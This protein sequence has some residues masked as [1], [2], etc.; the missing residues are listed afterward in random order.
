MAGNNRVF[1]A[2][3]ELAI[4]PYCSASGMP[5]HGVQSVN[6]TTTFNLEQVFELGQ[7]DI[8]ENIENIPNVELTAEKVL[9]GDTMIYH[10][11]TRGATSPSLLNRSNQRADV[12][13]MIFSDAQDSASG[14]P[15][16]Q[17]YCSGMYINALNYTLPVQGNC[18]ESVTLIGNDK[19]WRTANF[20]FNG[21]FDN[22]D[23]PP[24][25]V[26]RRQHVIMGASGVGSQWPTLIPG[27]TVTG[28]QGFNVETA[29]VFGAHV[30]DVTISTTLGREDLYELGRF[31]PYYR[32]AN[33]P[34]A[35][36]TTINVSAGGTNPGDA[37]N[38]NSAGNNLSAE[39]IVI[40]LADGTIFNMGND[41][42]LQS[43]TF[44]NLQ[45]GGGIATISYA[46]QNFNALTITSPADPQHLT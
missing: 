26:Q 14:S 12:F 1:Y 40:R 16:T 13:L 27:M 5:I 34:V 31:R 19:V 25:G 35:V 4:G 36:D 8:Y 20:Y 33:F 9:D 30:Q 15:M 18:T 37:V 44:S 38:A 2:I 39:T 41:N 17:A 21:H 6:L 32:Y 46:F 28:G 11:A 42:K 24:S 3:E 10:A 29:G 43:V 7:L 23:T 22:D 45:T